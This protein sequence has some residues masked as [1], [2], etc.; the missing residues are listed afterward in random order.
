MTLFAIAVSATS[1][2]A[3]NPLP[4]GT[5]SLSG[6]I[7]DQ[8][9]TPLIGATVYIPDLKLGVI[10]DTGGYYKFNSLP[11]GNPSRQV[12]SAEVFPAIFAR[13]CSSR[14][15]R[16]DWTFVAQTPRADSSEKF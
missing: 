16:S 10:T 13:Y 9:G 6:K 7:I 8:G 3:T 15:L 11:S 14:E 4:P 5:G 2:F 1:S 12:Q